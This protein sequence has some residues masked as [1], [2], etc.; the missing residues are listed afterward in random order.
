MNIAKTILLAGLLTLGMACGYGSHATTPPSAGTM[1]NIT[2]LVPNS[3]QAG[4]TN[5]GI[6]VNGT[7]FSGNAKVNWNGAALTTVFVSGNQLMATI[8]D[9][10]VAT[11]GT[12]AVTVTNPGM[13]GGLYGGG[14]SPETSSAMTFT[15]N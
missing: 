14:T 9:A 8:P 5:N 1:P 13:P 2:A 4:S 10:D 12:A 7:S 15:I 3:T 11:A 6:T